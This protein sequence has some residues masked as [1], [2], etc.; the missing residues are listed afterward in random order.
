[1]NRPITRP[2]PAEAA[3][4]SPAVPEVRAIAYLDPLEAFAP[5]ADQPFAILL[6]SPAPDTSRARYAYICLSPFAT[7]TATGDAICIHAPDGEAKSSNGNPWDALAELTRSFSSLPRPDLPPFQG[8][9][10]GLLGY[11]LNRFVEELP[12][13]PGTP[14]SCPDMAVGLYDVII[15]FDCFAERAWIVS[16][17]HPAT[18]PVDQ[19]RRARMRADWLEVELQSH[20]PSTPPAPP[21]EPAIRAEIRAE[22]PREA[23]LDRIRR[24]RD[25][26][27][28]GDI[29]QANFTQRFLG[30]LPE[31]LA[32]LTLYRRLRER[33]HAP[34]SA[35]MRI[36][37]A[38]CLLSVSPERFL[39]VDRSGRIETRPIKGTR[40]RHPDPAIDARL[41]EELLDSEKDRAENLMIVDL[42][43]NDLSR[44]AVVGSV[45]VPA[46]N[47]LESFETVHHLVST[48]EARLSPGL[49]ALELLRRAFP[50][51]SITGA[52]KIRAME[53]IAELEAA[54][55]GPYCGSAFWLDFSGGLD[56]SILI[57]SIVLADGKIII[58]AGG[59]IV[60]DSDPQAEYDESL[61]KARA[62][63][64]AVQLDSGEPTT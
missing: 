36:D 45:S 60:A 18:N 61:V 50:G 8:G 29:Y 17:G 23:Y 10:A 37:D 38:T 14:L 24:I 46:L 7:V 39:K 55:R 3:S 4:P 35:F 33:T 19:L 40:P 22:L 52:P 11:E 62:M 49:D 2:M 54:P 9:A 43:R 57:R 15:A 44:S 12:P 21:E 34:F 25:Y 47:V 51:G 20:L 30:R 63:I 1:M 26:I 58:Q 5:F 6:D 13:P 48:V 53:I 31:G 41:G 27:Y 42:L 59:G 16:S 64:E 32:P 56:S 28:A